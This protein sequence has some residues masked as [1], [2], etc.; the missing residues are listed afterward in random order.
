[1][2]RQL[3]GGGCTCTNGATS[4]SLSLSGDPSP[5]ARAGSGTG[6]AALPRPRRRHGLEGRRGAG[7]CARYPLPASP[8]SWHCDRTRPSST[9]AGQMVQDNAAT[10]YDQELGPHRLSLTWTSWSVIRGVVPASSLN[11]Q[12]DVF[13]TLPSA[14]EMNES[15]V[16][17][18]CSLDAAN[19]LG[20][21]LEGHAPA[22]CHAARS[23]MAL[24]RRL[25]QGGW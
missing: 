3:E 4:L 22:P 6:R 10:C 5:D 18:L 23:M 1:M 14:V 17:R 11:L 7:L 16:R 20:R 13:S 19:D 24:H 21:I 2:R 8:C 15:M 12:G 25:E 9:Y